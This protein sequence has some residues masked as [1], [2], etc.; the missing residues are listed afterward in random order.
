M[1]NVMHL[2]VGLVVITLVASGLI[3]G[4]IGE[5]KGRGNVGFFLGLLL[6]LVGLIIVGLMKPT[7]GVQKD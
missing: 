6:G 3:G 4:V 1:P 5:P 7:S 2:N